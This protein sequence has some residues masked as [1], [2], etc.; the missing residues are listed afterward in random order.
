MS[1][2]GYFFKVLS[3]KKHFYRKSLNKMNNTKIQFKDKTFLFTGTMFDIERKNAEKEVK[4]RGGYPAKGVNRT[5]DYLVIG[6]IPNKDWKFG[7]YGNKINES[8]QLRDL[9][10]NIKIIN[11]DDFITNLCETEPEFI[12]KKLEKISLIRF[13]F[14]TKQNSANQLKI[15]NWVENYGRVNN[16]FVDKSHYH[17]DI[18]SHLYLSFNEIDNKIADL[19]IN[20]R[21]IKH[22]DSSFETTG[23]NKACLDFV[24]E[25]NLMLTDFTSHEW[26]EGTSVFMKLL[27]ELPSEFKL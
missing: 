2:F 20:F 15:E 12:D 10:F 1:W 8:I 14:L 24:S 19:L 13:G 16:I 6:S 11:E 18:Y 25:I 26:Q 7:N 21:L 4:I 27:K 9:G 3:G 17:L 22:I 23:I 5:L